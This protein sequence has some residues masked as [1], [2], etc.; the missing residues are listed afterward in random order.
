[1]MEDQ[2]WVAR[3]LAGDTESYA[4]LVNKYKHRLVA[5]LVGMGNSAA[6]AEDIAQAAFVRAYKHLSKYNP[7]SKFPAWL[8]RIAVNLSISNWRKNQTRQWSELQDTL[9]GSEPSPEVQLLKQERRE[10]VAE[11]IKQLS[12]PYRTVLCMRYTQD[13]SYKEIAEV[14]EV[15]VTTVQVHLHRAKKKLGELMAERRDLLEV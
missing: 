9:V 8:N 4:H 5:M 10:E 6:D 15:P 13:M 12:L 14:L 1:M 3:V 11:A 7:E 2:E